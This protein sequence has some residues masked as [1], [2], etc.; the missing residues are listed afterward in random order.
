M[1][2]WCELF[3]EF[4]FDVDKNLFHDASQGAEFLTGN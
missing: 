4:N 1:K 2:N 3:L